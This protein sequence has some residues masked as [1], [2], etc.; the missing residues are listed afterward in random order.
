MC[1]RSARPYPLAELAVGYRNS[2][3][4]EILGENPGVM[5]FVFGEFFLKPSFNL[6]FEGFIA[7][8]VYNL[9]VESADFFFGFAD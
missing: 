8:A 5:M 2:F 9:L 6:G 3:K 7:Y 4:Q 1:R